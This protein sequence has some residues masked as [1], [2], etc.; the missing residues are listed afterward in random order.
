GDGR[1]LQVRPALGQ[2][3][4][5]LAEAQLGDRAQGLFEGVAGKAE[6]GTSDVHS[7]SLRGRGGRGRTAPEI[8]RPPYTVSAAGGEAR[9]SAAPRG[10][11]R[12]KPGTQYP[13]LSTQY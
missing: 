6:R 12:Y 10:D 4:V 3:H 9:F 5:H 8:D 1:R 11:S 7:G 2:H 13:V